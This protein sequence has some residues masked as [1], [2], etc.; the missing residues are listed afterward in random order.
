MRCSRRIDKI[1]WTDVRNEEL[2]R[3][4]K[5]EGNI[6]QTVERRKANWLGQILSRN[7]LLKHVIEGKIEVWIEVTRRRGK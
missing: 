1:S 4:A 7:C 6:L 2:L 5:E 3:R